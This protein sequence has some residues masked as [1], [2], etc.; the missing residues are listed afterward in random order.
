MA[1]AEKRTDQKTLTQNLRDQ[2]QADEA[3]RKAAGTWGDLSV[4]EV[5]HR[6]TGSVYV[7]V[8]KGGKRPEITAAT[9]R[10]ASVP[11]EDWA[12]IE[13]WLKGINPADLHRSII[14]WTVSKAEAARL[15]AKRMAENSAAGVRVINAAPG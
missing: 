13:G 10:A 5:T 6:A 4:G 11:T 12:A 15:K 9:A 14:A 7:Q 3:A 1:Q 8:W 2:R